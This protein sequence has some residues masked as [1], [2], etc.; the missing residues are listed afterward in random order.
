M[1]KFL[2]SY[3]RRNQNRKYK[4]PYIPLTLCSVMHFLCRF[5]MIPLSGCMSGPLIIHSKLMLF[6]SCGRLEELAVFQGYGYIVCE[7]EICQHFL[8]MCFVQG[9]PTQAPNMSCVNHPPHCR[10][11]IPVSSK[12]R[13]VICMKIRDKRKQLFP[14]HDKF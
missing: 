10:G 11:L 1:V 5:D 2:G 12:G 13:Q 7:V 3:Y 6:I 9:S 14:Y 8:S 4:V